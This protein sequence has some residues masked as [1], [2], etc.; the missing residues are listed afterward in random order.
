MSNQGD[1]HFKYAFAFV[2]NGIKFDKDK[3]TNVNNDTP[4]GPNTNA[5]ISI[6]HLD[7]Q[8]IEFDFPSSGLNLGDY[9][10]MFNKVA[11]QYRL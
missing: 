10:S 1:V 3:E 6:A 9:M 8:N 11:I 4:I 5:K 2:S 7:C